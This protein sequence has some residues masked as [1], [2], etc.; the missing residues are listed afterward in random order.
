MASAALS[1]RFTTTRWN[2]SRSRFTGGRPGAK[3]VRIEMPSRRP[4]KTASASSTTSFRSQR[5]GWAAGKRAN[6]ENS[7]TSVFTDSTDFEMVAAHSCRMRVGWRGG[8]SSAIEL[9]GDALGGERDRRQRILDLVRHAAR[10]LVPGGGLLRAQ[11]LAGVLEHDHEAGGELLFERRDRHREV[12]L[13]AW[14]CAVSSWREAMPVRRARFIRYLIS[15]VSSR[16]KRSSRRVALG[17]RFGREDLGE[18]PVHALDGAVGADRDDAGRDAFEDGFGEAAAAV[19][20]AAA[21]FQ[22][23]GHLVEAAHQEGQFVHR[24]DVHAV[25]Q[26]ALAHLAGGVAAGR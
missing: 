5:T 2:C 25:R 9:A 14:R 10:H 17:D 6:C 23:L 4:W 26:I 13:A 15:A 16:E 18:R 1:T 21:G 22:L 19:E 24:A 8:R 11:Q 7:S 3:L 20:F 12:Q